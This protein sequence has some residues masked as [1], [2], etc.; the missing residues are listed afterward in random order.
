MKNLQKFAGNSWEETTRVTDTAQSLRELVSR[1]LVAATGLATFAVGIYM[2]MQANIGVAP[3]DCFYLGIQETFGIQYGNV[4]VGI[5]ILIIIINLLMKERIG[6]GTILDAVI[7]GKSVDLCSYLELI[8]RQESIAGGIVLMLAGLLV[9]GLGQYIYM[10]MGLCCGPRDGLM[11]GLSKRMPKV[12][13]GMVSNMLI[14]LA[15]FLGWILGGPIGIGTVVA[16][17][18]MGP[19]MQLVF[20]VM[21]FDAAKVKHQDLFETFQMFLGKQKRR[22]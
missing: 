16:A 5:A 4:S 12:P 1:S 9:N 11:V 17:V 20:Y 3:W 21:H 13:I 14:A 22:L 2:T 7:V 8:P 19:A 10:R 6:I 15:L 18:C